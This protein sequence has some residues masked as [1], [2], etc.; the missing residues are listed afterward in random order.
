VAGAA[1]APKSSGWVVKGEE[2]GNE[3]L[4]KVRGQGEKDLFG[5]RRDSKKESA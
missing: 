2:K 1:D 4:L 3:F 5:S